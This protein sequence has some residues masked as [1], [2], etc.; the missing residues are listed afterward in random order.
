M[1]DVDAITSIDALTGL[2]QIGDKTRSQQWLD[3][4]DEGPTPERSITNPEE[5][6]NG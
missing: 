1:I 3:A 4:L 2:P 5:T 6:D